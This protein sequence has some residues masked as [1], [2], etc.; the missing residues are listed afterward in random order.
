M[1]NT[2]T[3]DIGPGGRPRKPVRPTRQMALGKRSHIRQ[4][5][6][7]HPSARNT[8]T[9]RESEQHRPRTAQQSSGSL[10]TQQTNVQHRS[11]ADSTK[12]RRKYRPHCPQR[13]SITRLDPVVHSLDCRCSH[14]RCCMGFCCC[15]C[16]SSCCCY[17][18]CCCSCRC[19]R[20]CCCCCGY[21]RHPLAT[22]ESAHRRRRGLCSVFSLP[23]PGT[24]RGRSGEGGLGLLNAGCF[25]P[26]LSSPTPGLVRGR[27]GGRLD[28]DCFS[29]RLSPP[30]RGPARGRQGGGGRS[31]SA[32][33]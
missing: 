29:P 7:Q 27:G 11:G 32:A 14:R 17:G 8:V 22:E 12:H 28:R 31:S 6:L 2:G 16:G 10:R 1:H 15:C 19:C 18:C 9:S 4:T 21:L 30:S 26:T 25:S 33:R 20:R 23:P 3:V 24:G 13:Q 5:N